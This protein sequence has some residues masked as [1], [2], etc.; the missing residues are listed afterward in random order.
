[1][2]D[3]VMAGSWASPTAARHMCSQSQL[4]KHEVAQEM[5]LTIRGIG[6]AA[7]RIIATVVLPALLLALVA[8][9]YPDGSGSG[10]TSSLGAGSDYGSDS[11]L[12]TGG[13]D[14]NPTA[15][16]PEPAT[17]VMLGA[18]LCALAAAKR[19]RRRRSR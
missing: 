8:G 18:G 2:L 5:S 3:Q 12:N 16:C 6:M 14:S 19:F 1:M 13:G 11:A 9:C 17:F 10:S 15:H 7:K 4:H